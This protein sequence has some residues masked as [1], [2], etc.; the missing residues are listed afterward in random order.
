M[1]KVAYMFLWVTFTLAV[2]ASFVTGKIAEA[3]TQV[4]LSLVALSLFYAFAVWSAFAE[5]DEN[6][7]MNVNR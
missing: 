6:E 1:L 4:V 2:G 7:G 3:G 5:R